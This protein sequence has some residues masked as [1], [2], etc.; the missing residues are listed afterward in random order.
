MVKTLTFT[1]GSKVY[2]DS[3]DHAL[4]S[5]FDWQIIKYDGRDS[6][7]ARRRSFQIF[8]HRLICGATETEQILHRNGNKLDNRK[9]NLMVNNKRSYGYPG[10]SKYRG[11][12]WDVDKKLWRVMV[13]I[14]DGNPRRVTFGRYAD[15]VHAAQVYDFHAKRLLGEFARLNF[16][17]TD[18]L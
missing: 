16:E 5:G 3:E 4:L 15:E 12:S 7:V 2:Y 17:G 1:D 10:S 13:Y 8:M 18:A 11:I 9:H 6:V 14:P